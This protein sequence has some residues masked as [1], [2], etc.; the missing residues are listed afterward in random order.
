MKYIRNIMIALIVII[1]IIVLILLMMNN[2][3]IEKKQEY[4]YENNADTTNIDASI[5]QVDNAS[6]YYTAYECLNNFYK[7]VTM[8]I[9]DVQE[10]YIEGGEIPDSI[11]M[12]VSSEEDRNIAI[13]NQLDKQYIEENKITQENVYNYFS[14]INSDFSVEKM[15]IINGELIKEFYLYVIQSGTQNQLLFNVVLD[16]NNKTYC[17]KPME[18]VDYTQIKSTNIASIELNNNNMFEY[19]DVSKEQ[20]AKKYFNNFKNNIFKDISKMYNKLEEQY[21]EKRF[22][23]LENYQQYIVDNKD[24]FENIIIKKY[25]V[26]NY[27]EYTE[28]VCQDQYENLY[29]F[30]EKAVMDYEL[31]LDTYTINTDKFITEYQSASEERKVQMNID[32]F[33]QMVNR[34]DYTTSYN[35]ISEGFKNNYFASQEQFKNYIKNV[36]FEYN[37]FEFKTIEKKGS[38]LY[39]STVQLTDLTGESTDVREINIIMQLN[40]NL[41]FEMSF[42]V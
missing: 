42:G 32:K 2:K 21:R 3:E 13:Y 4:S 6:L 1:I 31:L 29:V 40:D 30:R 22:G 39:V 10:D 12:G 36:F 35:C 41:D 34:H 8:E 14:F 25:L 37:K 33:I 17:I 19:A 24:E 16:V 11:L 9:S 5:K 20:M 23:S 26:N 18:T 28:Y 7:T 38:N 27:E 15:Y